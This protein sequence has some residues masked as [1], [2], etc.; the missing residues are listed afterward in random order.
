[1]SVTENTF[2]INKFI[3]S[4]AN[5]LR[6][7]YHSC[8]HSMDVTIFVVIGN[9]ISA[10]FWDFTQRRMVIPK[11][12]FR[13]TYRLFRNVPKF[14][15]SADPVYIVEEAWNQFGNYFDAKQFTGKR[16][17]CVPPSTAHVRKFNIYEGNMFA[18]R[19]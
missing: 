6:F 10:L 3:K 9:V 7:W 13:T 8:K 14:Q 16:P 1:M 15:K 12:D 2:Q 4:I 18:T 11:R 17:E 5:V 19:N